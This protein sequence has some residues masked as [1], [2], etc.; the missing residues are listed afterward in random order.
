MSTNDAQ[1]LSEQYGLDEAG[2]KYV[3]STTLNAWVLE[4]F[5]YVVYTAIYI[6]SMYQIRTPLPTVFP[7]MIHHVIVISAHIAP[8]SRLQQAAKSFSRHNYAPLG[9]LD[10]ARGLCMAFCQRHIH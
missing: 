6:L 5:C 8:E 4:I 7:C 2:V 10:H 9:H 1:P 3:L